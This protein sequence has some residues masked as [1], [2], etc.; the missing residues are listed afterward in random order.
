MSDSNT[1]IEEEK[2]MEVELPPKTEEDAEPEIKGEADF[3]YPAI[4]HDKL[5]EDPS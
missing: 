1:N 5:C 4:P 3:D 2:K